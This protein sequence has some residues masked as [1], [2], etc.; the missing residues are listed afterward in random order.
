MLGVI[1]IPGSVLTVASFNR[2][3][4]PDELLDIFPLLF[5]PRPDDEKQVAVV[6]VVVV[7]V[8]AGCAMLLGIFEGWMA[9]VNQTSERKK[10]HNLKQNL[11]F[12]KSSQSILPGTRSTHADTCS[13]SVGMDRKHPPN[14]KIFRIQHNIIFKQV[15]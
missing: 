7:I 12:S 1:V 3:V 13:R 5:P 2:R 4:D 8:T 6:N 10:Y 15:F 11:Q 9:P 14:N